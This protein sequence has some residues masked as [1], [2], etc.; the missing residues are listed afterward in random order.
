MSSGLQGVVHLNRCGTDERPWRTA[1]DRESLRERQGNMFYVS[2][3]N[4][5][6][7]AGFIVRKDFKVSMM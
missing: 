4:D 7:I 5:S 6:E 1:A 3:R 2:S